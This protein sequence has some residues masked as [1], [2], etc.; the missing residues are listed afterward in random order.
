M[1]HTLVEFLGE[2][3][4]AVMEQETIGVIGWDR[5]TQLLECPPCRGMH[6]TVTTTQKS[7]ATIAWA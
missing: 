7:Q 3:G 6:G 2:D 1:A 4:I 5:L